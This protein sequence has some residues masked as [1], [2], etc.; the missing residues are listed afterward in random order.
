MQI[1]EKMEASS[2]L[3]SGSHGGED[4]QPRIEISLKEKE[5]SKNIISAHPGYLQ[6]QFLG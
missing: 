5:I 4:E 3:R 2:E 1:L 6:L